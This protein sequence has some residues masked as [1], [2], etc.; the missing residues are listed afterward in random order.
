MNITRKLQCIYWYHQYPALISIS[1]DIHK[2]SQ[3]NITRELQCI[4]WYH[5]YPVIS[6]HLLISISIDIQKMSL[7]NITRKLQ[8]IYWYYQYPALIST[9]ISIS[10]DIHKMSLMNITG[11]LQWDIFVVYLLFC[12][13]FITCCCVSIACMFLCS[14]PQNHGNH[15]TIAESQ[16][17][18]KK[19]GRTV[20][21]HIRYQ[22]F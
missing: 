22:A 3:M 5:Q 13:M 7:M 21:R 17:Q 14:P 18:G 20:K 19:W 9:L 1:S 10:S 8:C 12:V 2:M 15:T 6:Y 16:S 11:E 4:Y